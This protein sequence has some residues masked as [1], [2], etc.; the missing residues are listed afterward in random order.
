MAADD[1]PPPPLRK[2]NIEAARE[3][4]QQGVRAFR[5]GR[6]EDAVR[7]FR[8]AYRLGGP[9][10]ELWNIARARERLDQPEA[11]AHAIEEYLA[12][13]TL[14]SDER[15][16]AEREDKAL[17]SRPSALTVATRPS[18]A[19]MAIDGRTTTGVTPLTLEI[20]AGPHTIAI[21]RAGYRTLT[22]QLE[23]RFGR[24]VIV[25][26]EL[27]RDMGDGAKVIP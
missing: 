20:R 23:A 2:A 10:S 13:S 27:A 17:R 16:E 9:A 24:A 22:R 25:E 18:G 4:D 6:Y 11:A 3:L 19:T 15:A 14:T 5:D 8:A 1:P 26:L 21:K 7:Y 12:Q